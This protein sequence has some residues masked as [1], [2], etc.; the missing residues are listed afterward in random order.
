[1]VGAVDLELRIRRAALK[2]LHARRI[3]Y[4]E[5]LARKPVALPPFP[6]VVPR[7]LVHFAL[8]TLE[9]VALGLANAIREVGI[10]LSVARRP[11]DLAGRQHF[12]L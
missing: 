3:G 9:T 1:M 11:H 12:G 10:P 8:R 7:H 4:D 6:I 2:E 5:R